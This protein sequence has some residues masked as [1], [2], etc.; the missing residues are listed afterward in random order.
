MDNKMSRPSWLDAGFEQLAAHGP[1]GLRIMTIAKQLGVT[2]GSF[3]WHF[4]NLREYRAALLTEW[5]RRYTHQIIEQVE[6]AGGDAAAKLR[7]LMS[8][9]APAAS[10]GPRITFALRLWAMTDPLVGKIVARVDE[11]RL[12][13]LT[14]LLRA[15]G[16]GKRDAMTLARFAQQAL[17]GRFMLSD[18]PLSAAQNDLIFSALVPK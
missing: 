18:P 14:N 1:H 16:W 11:I 10:A 12:A 8:V 6:H 7:R 5:E 9:S 4:K 13:Y 15:L 2:K 17:I 3:Y